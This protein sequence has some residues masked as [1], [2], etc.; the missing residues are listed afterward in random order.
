MVEDRQPFTAFLLLPQPLEPC[1]YRASFT[2]TF[3]FKLTLLLPGKLQT[4]KAERCVTQLGQRHKPLPSM[5]V[6]VV[7]K[8][9]TAVDSV[10]KIRS[11]ENVRRQLQRGWVLF[12][13]RGVTFR[14]LLRCSDI[15]LEPQPMFCSS[16]WSRLEPFT[17]GRD[18]DAIPSLQG[19]QILQA[20]ELVP[21]CQN[22]IAL[23]L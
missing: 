15:C 7:A 12:R 18:G 3:L 16:C 6:V 22:N 21:C 14:S 17:S 9:G 2:G 8:S 23:G 4:F 13:T 10:Q 5:G 11:R 20:Q 1:A 19:E